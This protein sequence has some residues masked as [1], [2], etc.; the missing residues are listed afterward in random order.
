VI[1]KGQ[2]KA[3]FKDHGGLFLPT[4]DATE[5]ARCAL[6][7]LVS[8]NIWHTHPLYVQNVH[9]FAAKGL[10]SSLRDDVSLR[11]SHAIILRQIG[12]H[13]VP[14]G[15]AKANVGILNGSRSKLAWRTKLLL[16][17]EGKKEDILW[18]FLALHTPL[19]NSKEPAP[20]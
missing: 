11:L 5:R 7:W 17:T 19:R 4:D 10:A 6:V 12:W 18:N 2:G 1:Q 8:R 9:A 13:Q 15:T 20:V 16:N 14:M 3:I